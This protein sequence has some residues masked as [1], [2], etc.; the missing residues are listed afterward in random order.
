[1][2]D[3]SPATIDALEQALLTA[4]DRIRPDWLLLG[5][6][7]DSALLAAMWRHHGHQFRA[8][9]VGRDS[10]FT[11]VPAHQYLPY[12]CNSDL[13]W[14]EKVAR[15]LELDW[16]PIAL[17][18]REAMR[19][20]DQL[21]VQE[22]SFDLGQLNNIAL[23]AALD[24]AAPHGERTTFATGDDGDGLFGGYLNA[25]T[26]EDWGAW[27]ASRIPRINP[28]ARAIG[29][30][31]GWQPMFPYL[32]PEVLEVVKNLS[33]TDIRQSVPVSEH[34]LPPSFMDQFD[35]DAVEASER[36]WGKVILRQVAER[37]L[38]KELAWRPKTDLQFGS[39]M[40]ALEHPLAMLL[41]TGHR[42]RIQQTGMTFFNDSHRGLYSRF[43]SLGAVPPPVRDGE[44]PC[45]N[46]GAGV[47]IGKNHCATCGHWE[48]T[49]PTI[50]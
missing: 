26:H 41:N 2:N 25:A 30:A 48:A 46:C 16:T 33:T 11:C 10:S 28:P 47:P 1:M 3:T 6:G 20:L 7:V 13:E 32:E 15:H 5:G 17:T 50:R 31:L 42:I 14:S 23:I 12:T 38:P 29:T 9:T 44:A 18:E 34:P 39:G 43:L 19:Y 35:F 4:T 49:S 36:T 37:Y 27:I 22:E 21:V 40:C 24:Q 8:I 45:P